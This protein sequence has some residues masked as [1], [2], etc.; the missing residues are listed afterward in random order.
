MGSVTAWESKISLAEDMAKGWERS[1]SELGIG[2]GEELG[3][4]VVGRE[5]GVG[6]GKGEGSGVG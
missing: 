4:G 3:S 1:R 5:V 6:V 2:L